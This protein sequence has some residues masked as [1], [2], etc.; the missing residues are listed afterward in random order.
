ML[1]L[2]LG[3]VELKHTWSI[4]FTGIAGGAA[5]QGILALTIIGLN[6][7]ACKLSQ[8]TDKENREK[9]CGDREDATFHR[10][11]VTAGKD[12]TDPLDVGPTL[13]LQTQEVDEGESR[14]EPR[15]TSE[16]SLLL[17]T[18]VEMSFLNSHQQE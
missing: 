16:T 6:Y 4:Y 8:R 14:T 5:I 15:E 9:L 18:D 17:P 11:Q 13:P 7:D 1:D 12:S 3:E 2:N 10:I